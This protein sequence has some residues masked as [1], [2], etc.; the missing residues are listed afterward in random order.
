MRSHL[1]VVY[2]CMNTVIK[3]IS[4]LCVQ[5]K[6]A[7]LPELPSIG[8]QLTVDHK[9]FTRNHDLDNFKPV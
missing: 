7:F 1:T 5:F 6:V 8:P 9:Y 2:K 3:A 4:L